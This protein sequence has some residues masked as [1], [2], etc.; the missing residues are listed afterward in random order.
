V[1]VRAHHRRYRGKALR[2]SPKL[3]L[4]LARGESAR[5]LP[6]AR[7]GTGLASCLVSRLALFSRARLRG[8]HPAR[9]RQGGLRSRPR[10]CSRWST[11]THECA[12]VR[13]QAAGPHAAHLES[14]PPE[15]QTAEGTAL[16]PR[17]AG[18]DRTR[19]LAIAIF[20][21]VASPWASPFSLK[22]RLVTAHGT[23]CHGP[24][25]AYWEESLRKALSAWEARREQLVRVRQGWR[26]RS[27]RCVVLWV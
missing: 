2:R 10:C 23:S 17:R 22:W 20:D 9:C 3:S 14:V 16:T 21:T 8:A 26:A 18:W 5:P 15:F 4:L 7:L 24:R 19:R 6:A 1:L 27:S 25:S 12:C 11:R 13:R